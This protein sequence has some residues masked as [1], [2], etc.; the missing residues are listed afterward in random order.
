VSALVGVVRD[1]IFEVMRRDWEMGGDVGIAVLSGGLCRVDVLCRCVVSMW[2]VYIPKKW[3]YGPTVCLHTLRVW[4]C[5]Q[6]THLAYTTQM[7]GNDGKKRR[8]VR[9]LL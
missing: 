3:G 4:V 9:L 1:I 6:P 5:L 8:R 2:C 7:I